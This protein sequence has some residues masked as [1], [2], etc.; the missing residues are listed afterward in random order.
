VSKQ[1]FTGCLS[2]L[3]FFD[4][5]YILISTRY[6]LHSISATTQC[7]SDN[8][9]AHNHKKGE[10]LQKKKSPATMINSL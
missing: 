5:E 9:D 3:L 6:Q 8:T 7:P 2:V 10:N 1:F 4:E